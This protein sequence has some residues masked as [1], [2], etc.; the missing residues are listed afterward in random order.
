MDTVEQYIKSRRDIPPALVEALLEAYKICHQDEPDGNKCKRQFQVHGPHAA[1]CSYEVP[2]TEGVVNGTACTHGADEL[3]C[4]ARSP[5]CESSHKDSPKHMPRSNHSETE[6]SKSPTIRQPRPGSDYAILLENLLQFDVL[7]GIARTGKYY[8]AIL[9]AF[10]RHEFEGSSNYWTFTVNGKVIDEF[11]HSTHELVP[12]NIPSDR[13]LAVCFTFMTE[14]KTAETLRKQYKH[15]DERNGKVH[16]RTFFKECFYDHHVLKADWFAICHAKKDYKE[17]QLYQ[18]FASLKPYFE[19]GRFENPLK[20]G[21]RPSDTVKSDEK[22]ASKPSPDN[23]IVAIENGDDK[24]NSNTTGDTKEFKQMGECVMNTEQK[25]FVDFLDKLGKKTGQTSLME[26]VKQG[27]K[28]CFESYGISLATEPGEL[29]DV[30]QKQ[31]MDKIKELF[32]S[33][34]GLNVLFGNPREVDGNLIVDVHINDAFETT[35]KLYWDYGDPQISFGDMFCGEKNQKYFG[36]CKH[37]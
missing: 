15:G 35:G 26:A 30:R 14:G 25:M 18:I 17:S 5:K 13:H 7:N 34:T 33:Q 3:R 2:C 36:M 31:V 23:T 29:Y 10:G 27:Y 6:D 20:Q 9:T 11:R 21:G 4:Q 37:L 24:L 28:A 32:Y 12:A 16:K 1:P 19:T 8:D 22:A